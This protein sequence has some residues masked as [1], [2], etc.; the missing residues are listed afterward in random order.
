MK[1]RLL[2]LQLWGL[3]DLVIATP[4]LRAAA[5]KFAVTLVAKPFAAELRPRLWPGIEVITFTAPWT[6]FHGKYHLWRWPW[7]EML[8]LRRRL[9]GQPFDYGVSGR[10]DPRDHW[11]LKTFG[12]VE[13]LGFSRL[14][15]RR[16]LTR[17]LTRPQPLAH[18]SEYWREAGRALGLEVPG[19]SE[20]ILP[21]RASVSSAL[22]HS[23]ARLSARVWPLENFQEIAARLRNKNIPVQIACDP[24]QRAWWNRQGENAVCPQTVPELLALIDR[25]GIFVGNCSGPGHLAAICGV[26]TFT[27]FGPSMHEWWVPMHPAA[28][29]FEGKACPYKPCSDYCR[30]AKPFCLADVKAEEVWPRVEKFAAKNLSPAAPRPICA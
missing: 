4:F 1:P 10:W 24:D 27:L 16:Y 5:E 29:I 15:S 17:E 2:V 20:I 30:Y 25:A 18:M 3:G 6:A 21:P 26:P 13:R 14:N 8:R 11:L 19:R 7:L 9:V 12:A 23:G 28:E 22:L